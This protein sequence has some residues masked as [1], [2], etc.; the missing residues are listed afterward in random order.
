MS[1]QV[2]KLEKNMAK[3]TIEVSAEEVEKAIEKAYQKQKSRISVPGFRKGKVPRKMV[4]KMYGVGVFYEDAVNDMIPT[5][6]EAAVK[7]SELEIVSQP[8]IDVVQI[9]AGKEFI[10]TAEVAVKPEVELGEYKGVEVPKSDVSVSDEEIMA[11]IYKERE[12]NSRIITVDDRAVE[13]GDMTVIDFEG[14][15][16]GVA[17]EG[18]KGTDYPLTI[19]SH[20]FIDTFEEQLIGKNIGEEVDVNVTFPEE[21]HAEELKGKPALFKVTVKEIKKKELPELDNDFVEDVSEFSTV[22]EYKASIKTKIEEKKA[23]EAKSAKEEATIEKII[24][25]AKMEIPDAMVDSQVRQMAE[26]F[27]RR[28]SAQ[29]LTIDQYFQ[30]T[31]LTSDKLLE[32]MRP[33]ALKRI[34]S[35]LVLEAVADKENFEVTDEDVNN[36]IN[37]MASAYQMEADKLKDLLTDADK[38]NMKRDIQVK[39][40]V[41]FVTENAK[42][43]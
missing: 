11:E 22:D 41:E 20:S 38:E 9:E 24:E 5:A 39:K 14:F 42:E 10:F 8:K 29:G 36:E 25:G 28:I 34:Q 35:R 6:Y 4:E 2:E 30:Y 43:V 32:Q 37:D 19:G 15:V 27:A 1:L 12:Q 18:G 21:Y 40:A 13:D 23:D 3:L 33:Q 16:D 31:G 17:F 7:E 26:D